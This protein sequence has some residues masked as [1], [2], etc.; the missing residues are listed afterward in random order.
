MAAMKTVAAMCAVLACVSMA[1]AMDFY[2]LS[3]IDIEG[4]NVSLSTYRGKV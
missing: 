3:A 4:K 2:S 1:S